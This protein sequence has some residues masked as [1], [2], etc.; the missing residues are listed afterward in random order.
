[1]NSMCKGLNVR[2]G[3]EISVDERS[4]GEEGNGSG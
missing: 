1:M 4:V 3:G 2:A